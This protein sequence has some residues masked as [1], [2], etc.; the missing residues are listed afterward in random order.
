M[1]I[2][3]VSDMGSA[4]TTA[5]DLMVNYSLRSEVCFSSP[6]IRRVKPTNQTHQG[7]T[8]KFWFRPDLDPV[9]TALTEDTDVTAGKVSDTSIDVTITEYGAAT[10]KTLKAE[11]V[12]MIGYDADL[13][14]LNGNQAADSFELLARAAL[15]TGATAIRPGDKAQNALLATDTLK[16]HMV[17]KAVAKLRRDSVGSFGG[18]YM[19]FVAPET[20]LD[21]RE[22]T[23]DA[24]WTTG[25]NYSEITG[26]NNGEIGT[27]AGG[28]FY[29]TPRIATL[30]DA[31]DSNVDVYQNFAIGEEALA[32]AYSRRVSAETPQAKISPVTDKLSRFH[33]VGWY[34][35]G[36]FKRFR[37][38][39]SYVLETA[40]SIGDNA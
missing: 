39:A 8:V 33:H 38:E 14:R 29:E 17:R 32:S 19:F 20:S 13:A 24:A 31:G 18:K 3:Q 5:Y 27:F 34:W 10:G 21:L 40:S 35:L 7:S 15:T 12:D 16:A 22:E 4:G 6:M 11:G 9:T 2:T 1:A 28:I 36:G 23:G 37:P 26:I 25:R 30:A